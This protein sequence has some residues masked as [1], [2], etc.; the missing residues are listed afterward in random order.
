M[1]NFLRFLIYH[2]LRVRIFTNKCLKNFAKDIKNK[3]IL[4]I[5]S[6][7]DKNYLAK[8]NFDNSNEFMQSDVNP[9]YGHRVIDVTKMNFKNEFDVILCIN[10]L[11]HVFDFKKAIE[12]I[13]KGLKS[14]GI[15]LFFV[16]GYYPLHDEPYDFW[17]FSE[18]SLRRLL[19][20]FKYIKIKHCGLRRY[21]FGYFIETRK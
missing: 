5:G 10:V 15:A 8:K 13:Y 17:R 1:R 11:E 3:K 4:E 18:H 21:P 6:G 14:N 9:N 20:D 16:P 7:K 2:T 19:K 12:N